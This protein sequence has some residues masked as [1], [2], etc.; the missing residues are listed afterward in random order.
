MKSI[1]VTACIAIA[2]LYAPVGVQAAEGDS[3]KTIVKDSVITTKVK[4]KLAEDK[5]SSLVNI[6]VDTDAKGVV[7][8]GGTAKTQEQADKA[9]ALARAT[10]GVT[11]VTSTIVVKKD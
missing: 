6:K 4:A 8:L 11:S 1:L 9:V 5:V 3:A 10:E 7:V 2:T